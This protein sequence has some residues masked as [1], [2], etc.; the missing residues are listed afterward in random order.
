MVKYLQ[1]YMAAALI[2]LAATFQSCNKDLESDT[3]VQAVP[4]SFQEIKSS[5][6]FD[7][8]TSKTIDVTVAGIELPVALNYPLKVSTVEGEVVYTAMWTMQN[9]EVF[10][11]KIPSYV[12]TL[13]FSW[14]SLEKTAAVASPTMTFTFVNPETL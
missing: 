11:I 14:G 5:S 8:E 9:D 1:S 4:E 10:Q 7:W 13:V 2:M 12:E 3:A 6:S